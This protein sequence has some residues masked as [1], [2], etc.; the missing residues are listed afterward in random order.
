MTKGDTLSR[1]AA[2]MTGIV[3][4]TAAAVMTLAYCIL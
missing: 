4:L 3:A 2:V 1:R